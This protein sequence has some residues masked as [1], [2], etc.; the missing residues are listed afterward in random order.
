MRIDRYLPVL[1]VLAAFVIGAVAPAKANDAFGSK[2]IQLIVGFTPGGGSDTAARVIAPILAK[3]LRATVI[4]DNK[5]G[6]AGIIASDFVAKAKPD[7]HTLLVASPGAFTI[8]PYLNKLP[9]DPVKDFTPVSQLTF[10]PNIMVAGAETG[11]TSV[12][13]LIAKT[14][15]A[16]G[17]YNFA[18]TGVGATPH[19]AFAYFSMLT[20]ID[21][22]HVP[23]K[24]NPQAVADVLGGRVEFYVADPAAVLPH[25]QTGKLR[26][27]ALSTK[28]KSR[29]FPDIPS[30]TEAGVPKFDVPFWHG[31]MAPKGLPDDIVKKLLAALSVIGADREVNAAIEK[32][33]MELRLSNPKDFAQM[34]DGERARWKYVIETNNI[35]AE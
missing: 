16:P 20:G 11:I 32:A 33:G 12:S 24:G 4:V 14:K 3:E 2:P 26:A 30:M 35:K 19:L 5:P 17:K 15:A 27:L 23:Y 31:L 28:D 7:G 21:L 13:E 34:M 8:A 1:A 29:L 6:A 9:Y 25:I 10:Y 18:S 22:N